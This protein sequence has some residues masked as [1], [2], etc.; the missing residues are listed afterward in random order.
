MDSQLIRLDV[1]T[2]ASGSDQFFGQTGRFALGDQ[3][4]DHIAAE[5]I[6]DVVQKILSPLGRTEQ[7]GNIPAPQLVGFGRQ[8]LGLDVIGVAQLIAALA[9]LL[10]FIQNTVH[11]PHGAQIPPFIDQGRI[12]FPRGL[13]LKPFAVENLTNDG[14]LSL[15]EGARRDDGQHGWLWLSQNGLP[16]SVETA[17][18]DI[19]RLASVQHPYRFGELLGRLDHFGSSGL[20]ASI[21]A[22][23]I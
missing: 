20:V 21:G 17:P 11:R 6:Q 23:S 22:P 12:D 9:Y 1:L 14:F 8:Q 4:A 2:Q 15:A 19:E 13:V 7:L 18:G 3:P 16:S 10:I 5:N